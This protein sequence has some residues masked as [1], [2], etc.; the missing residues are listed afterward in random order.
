[1]YRAEMLSFKELPKIAWQPAEQIAHAV[2]ELLTSCQVKILSSFL[3]WQKQ[4]SD[5]KAHYFAKFCCTSS[6]C[7]GDTIPSQVQFCHSQLPHYRV[8]L[9]VAY[10]VVPLYLNL[11]L[12]SSAKP[13]Y[14]L[15]LNWFI[16]FPSQ[17]AGG[18][19]SFALL[20]LLLSFPSALPS[21]AKVLYIL[22]K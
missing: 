2:S 5:S 3:C 9:H 1:M 19:S 12:S 11:L 17:P 14:A 20:S 15:N 13:F 22:M 6:S 16:P 8:P 7:L 18:G 10:L 4:A 21:C